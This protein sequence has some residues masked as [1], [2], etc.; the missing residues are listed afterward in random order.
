[1]WHT[2]I[3]PDGSLMVCPDG[4]DKCDASAMVFW[5]PCGIFFWDVDLRSGGGMHLNFM[6]FFLVI[7]SEIV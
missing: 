7:F 3:W 4:A 5:L 6:L 2:R 1:M